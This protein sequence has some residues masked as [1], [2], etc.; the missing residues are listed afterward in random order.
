[1]IELE[2][3]ITEIL[4]VSIIRELDPDSGMVLM[5]MP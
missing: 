4:D 1:M 2:V 5:K 3:V